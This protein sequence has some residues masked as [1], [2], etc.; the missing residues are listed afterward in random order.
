ML[1]KNNV[2]PLC[3]SEVVLKEGRFGKF[4]S[5]SSWPKCEFVAN[6]EGN[7]DPEQSGVFSKALWKENEEERELK[8]IVTASLNGGD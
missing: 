6:V 8:G 3:G 1:H 2:C 4:F 5:C 7:E